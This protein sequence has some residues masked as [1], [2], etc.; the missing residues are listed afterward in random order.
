MK[1]V[2]MDKVNKLVEWVTN[3]IRESETDMTFAEMEEVERH[4]G[5]GFYNKLKQD[6]SNCAKQIL[7][8][9][10]L[11]LIKENGTCFTYQ[12]GI[13]LAYVISLSEAIKEVT[14]GTEGED[15]N[16]SLQ[17]QQGRCN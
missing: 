6:Y 9:P 1:R 4:L 11:A 14:D 10:D 16:N 2:E 12:T 13:K 5:D 15:K 17:K 8:Y 3:I 7:S